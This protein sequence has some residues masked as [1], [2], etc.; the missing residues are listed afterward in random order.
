MNK[1]SAEQIE[2]ATNEL[3]SNVELYDA[4]PLTE[5]ELKKISIEARRLQ[6]EMMARVFK[7][8]VNGVGNFFTAIQ[9]GLH[10][11]KRYE[12]LANLSDRDLADLGISRSDIAS[13]AFNESSRTATADL[14]VYGY[15]VKAANPTNDWVN[16]AAA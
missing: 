13:V 12:E 5:A 11:S 10:A 15:D 16:K 2:L 3:V 6:A 1:L 9:D 7:A 8:I 14:A 4:K